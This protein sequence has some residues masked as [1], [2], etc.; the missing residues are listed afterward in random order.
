MFMVQCKDKPGHLQT[1]LDNRAAHL[2]YAKGFGA[3]VVIGGPLLSDDGQTMI[4][5]AFVFDTDDRAELDAF[6]AGD[7]YG[8][9]G[10]FESVTV[11]RYRKVLP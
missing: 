8:K 2:E 9:A 7:P 10:L 1:R 4:G 6:L 3:K 11:T 5:S